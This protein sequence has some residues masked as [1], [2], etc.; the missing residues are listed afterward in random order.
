MLK[1]TLEDIFFNLFI[2]SRL[3]Q[4]LQYRTFTNDFNICSCIFSIHN[5]YKTLVWNVN[6]IANS[7][8]SKKL[9]TKQLLFIQGASRLQLYSELSS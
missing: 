5:K 8:T 9:I 3:I 1:F 7:T 6:K 2:L 4:S